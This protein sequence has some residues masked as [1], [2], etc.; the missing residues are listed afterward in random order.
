MET[1]P[2]VYYD[3]LGARMFM[4]SAK[5]KSSLRI[6]KHAD[7][8]HVVD[9]RSD[10]GAMTKSQARAFLESLFELRGSSRREPD[11]E[12]LNSTKFLDSPEPFRK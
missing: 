10:F 2:S 8:W 9:D 7:G 11:L 6:E 1:K 3:E 5:P 12:K 4:K